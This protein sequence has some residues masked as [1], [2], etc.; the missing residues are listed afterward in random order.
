MVELVDAVIELKNAGYSDD[1]IINYLQQQGI[2]PKDILNAIKKSELRL[3]KKI[4]AEGR[5]EEINEETGNEVKENLKPS[6]MDKE[7]TIPMPSV[8][9]STGIEQPLK[10]EEDLPIKTPT[11]EAIPQ[12]TQPQQNIMP[13]APFSQETPEPFEAVSNVY[14]MET[15]ETLAEQI[16][17]ERWNELI[18]RIG[19]ITELKINIEGRI[20]E[21]ESRLKR[22][23]NN[24]DKIHLLILKRQEQQEKEMHNIGKE[25]NML[26]MTFKKILKPLSENIKKLEEISEEFKKK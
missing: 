17:N 12:P 2:K 3:N 21:I 20:K 25:I 4:G 11:M 8:S 24:L 5:I 1:Q 9:P 6:I 15:I 13:V 10:K 14:D 19:D 16:I 18:K 7:Q 22:V 26:E 23:E